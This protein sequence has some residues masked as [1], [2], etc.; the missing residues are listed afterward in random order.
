MR[1]K[2]K[3]PAGKGSNFAGH[4]SGVTEGSTD[5]PPVSENAGV[6][7]VGSILAAQE[8]SEDDEKQARRR[9]QRRGEEILDHL[10]EIRHHIL[11]GAVPKDRLT[12]LVQILRTKRTSVEDP[13]LLSIIDD[14][15]LRA[16]VEIA[17]LTRKI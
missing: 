11:M 9:L 5:A 17:K 10:D 1:P 12:H 8:V 14:I 16:E 15:E 4:L 3:A 13:G 6:G 2:G 7:P